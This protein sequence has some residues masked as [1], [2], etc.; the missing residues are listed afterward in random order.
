MIDELT[1]EVIDNDLIVKEQMELLVPTEI[2]DTYYQ[3]EACREKIEAWQ[4]QIKDKVKELFKQNGIKSFE[5]DY[6]QITYVAPTKRKSVD[7]DALK[8]CGLYD[9]F[10]KES[11][12]KES[13]RVKVK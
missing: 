8:K 10:T 2:L 3:M 9:Q 1:G 6:I 7:T 5:N 4:Y 12:V 13:L 11:E